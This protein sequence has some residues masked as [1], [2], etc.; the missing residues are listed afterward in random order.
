MH[1]ASDILVARGGARGLSRLALAAVALLLT[2]PLQADI[3]HLK[4]G[5][6][7]EGE[8]LDRTDQHYRIRTNVG[9]ISIPV[10]AVQRVE[11]SDTILAEYQKRVE[12][13]PGS[14]EDHFALAEWCEEHGLTAQRTHHLQQAVRIDPDYAPARRALGYV[15]VGGLWV[16]G[17]VAGQQPSSAPATQS[18][19]PEDDPQ[20]VVSAIQGQWMRRIRAIQANLL[21][22]SKERLIEEGRRKILQIKDPLAILPLARVLSEGKYASRDVL[23]DALKQFP[24]DE[25]TMNLTV[26]ALVDPE[27]DVR[28]R[29]AQELSKR[30]DPRVPAQFREALRSDSDA[31]IRHAAEALQVIRDRAAIPDLI[32]VL[33]ARRRRNVEVPV[34]NYIGALPRV[35]NE[36]TGVT[37]GHNVKLQHTP[38]IGVGLTVAGGG[39][40]VPSRIEARDVTVFR[41]EVLEALKAI[42]GKNFGFDQTAWNRWYSE[43]RP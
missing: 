26:L 17:S 12:A 27:R 42:T 30:D 9:I 22:S 24:Q 43:G 15:R 7:I 14:A 19:Q 11:Q 25:A 32:E 13:L 37:F 1:A 38:V 29:A 8:V 36:P 18:P 5:G 16:D 23:V 20:R 40:L 3:L 2:G 28:R 33:T 39:I 41:T 10:D 35:F 6:A 4:S 31:L 21:D 34:Q